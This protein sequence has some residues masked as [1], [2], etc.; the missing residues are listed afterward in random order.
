MSTV[1]THDSRNTPH[2]KIMVFDGS[3]GVQFLMALCS[4]S[5]QP[6][7]LLKRAKKVLMGCVCSFIFFLKNRQKMGRMCALSVGILM[8]LPSGRILGDR[9]S[10]FM[11]APVLGRF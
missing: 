2:L 8:A 6:M 11:M 5:G 4:L 7:N 9:F 3:F 1:T 10:S